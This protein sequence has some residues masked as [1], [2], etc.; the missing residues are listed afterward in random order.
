VRV[1]FT[2][3]GERIPASTGG[4]TTLS[5]VVG[6]SPRVKIDH[7]NTVIPA[8]CVDSLGTAPIVSDDTCPE[9]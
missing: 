2:E 6:D 7:R 4:Y 3:A 5:L 9:S 1:R 8:E